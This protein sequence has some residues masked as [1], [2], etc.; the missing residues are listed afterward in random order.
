[1]NFLFQRISHG[2][3]SNRQLLRK[4]DWKEYCDLLIRNLI[5]RKERK[6]KLPKEVEKENL[7]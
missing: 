6:K 4:V 2:I 7:I 5:I 3:V 1:M